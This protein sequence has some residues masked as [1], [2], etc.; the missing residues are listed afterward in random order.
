LASRWGGEE[1]MIICS[2][3][4]LKEGINIA[5]RLRESVENHNF[6][7]DRK[8]T[9]SLGVVEYHDEKMEMKDVLKLVDE[10]LYKAKK[11][12]RNKTIY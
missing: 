10:K 11:E 1:F 9:I 2:N 4:N 5:E 3:T 12:G 6:G 8:V 7:I